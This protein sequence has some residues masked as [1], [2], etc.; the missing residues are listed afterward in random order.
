MMSSRQTS[1][2]SAL[3][4]SLSFAFIPSSTHAST[5]TCTAVDDKASVGANETVSITTER[6]ICRFSVGGASVDQSAPPPDFLNALNGLLAG[7]MDSSNNITEAMVANL[8]MG[9]GGSQASRSQIGNTV[10]PLLQDISRCIADARYNADRGFFNDSSSPFE[11]D[12][13]SCQTLSASSNRSPPR[14][15]G[16]VQVAPTELMLRLAIQLRDQTYQ[17]FI[18]A[19]AILRGKAGFR[20]Q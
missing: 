8:L 2:L 15:I 7:Q 9:P 16:F 12:G 19:R 14:P 6:K 13:V 18:P 10:R 1:I 11:R 3:V 20:Y 4:L 5:F 17:I